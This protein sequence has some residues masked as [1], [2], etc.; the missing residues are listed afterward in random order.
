MEEA[1]ELSD[2]IAI[3]DH[4][5]VIAEGTHNELVRIVGEL[6]RVELTFGTEITDLLE[7]WKQI[8]GVKS[9]TPDTTSASLM[10]ED[11]DEALPYFFEAAARDHLKITSVTVHEPN[12][13]T[14]FLHLTGR[15][16]RE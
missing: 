2:R 15:A 8:P 10:V 12:L 7:S 4:G 13:E 5:K 3:I 6:D 11:S 16:L 14:V 9:V 1:Q